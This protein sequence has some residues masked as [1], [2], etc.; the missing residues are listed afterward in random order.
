V[1]GEQDFS[2]WLLFVEHPSVHGGDER[3]AVDEVHLQGENAEQ[4]IAI[5]VGPISWR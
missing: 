3:V 4:Q 1:L 5:G 2:E